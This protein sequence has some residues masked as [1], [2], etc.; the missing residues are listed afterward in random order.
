MRKRTRR[1]GAR[2]PPPPPSVRDPAQRPA[3]GGDVPAQLVGARRL[4]TARRRLDP[5]ELELGMRGDRGGLPPPVTVDN[6]VLFPG[7]NPVHPPPPREPHGTAVFPR[8]DLDRL[9]V[10]PAH[11]LPCTSPHFSRASRRH[12]VVTLAGR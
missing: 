9:A 8:L 10:H 5:P 11:A 3:A 6:P 1:A 12:R 4:A 2:P 7:D